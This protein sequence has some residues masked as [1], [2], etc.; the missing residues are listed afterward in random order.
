[1]ALGTNS[2]SLLALERDTGKWHVFRVPYPLGFFGRGVDGHGVEDGG[3]AAE[4]R[5]LQY[6]AVSL[7]IL[8]F[9]VQQV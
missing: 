7:P 1:M 8:I 9:I 2:D 3:V 5:I 6:H 4:P